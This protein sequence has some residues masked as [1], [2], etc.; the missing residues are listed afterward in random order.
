MYR[1]ILL[2]MVCVVAVSGH[3]CLLNPHQR[4]SLEGLNKPG[5]VS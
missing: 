4:G 3:L 2:L 1:S 5:I